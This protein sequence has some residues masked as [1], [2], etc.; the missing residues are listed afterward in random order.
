MDEKS[1]LARPFIKYF[2]FG[3]LTLLCGLGLYAGW[4]Y[5][6]T[7]TIEDPT[8]CLT[9]QMNQIEL[10]PNRTSY[11]HYKEVPKHFFQALILSEDA[12][13]YS[14]KG[15]DWFEIKESFR[16][17]FV[18]WRFSRGGSTLTQQLAKNMY[19]SPEKSLSRKFK[20]FFI[21]KQLERKLSKSQI[22]EK[23]VNIVEFG[24]NIYGLKT[25]AQHYFDKT[26]A[27][28]N[29][30]ESVYLVSLLPSPRRLGKSHYHQK[31]SKNNLWRMQ[32]ILRRLYHTG[33]LKDDLYVYMKVLLEEADWPFPQYSDSMFSPTVEQELIE[34]FKTI[35]E[36]M[37][38]L[39]EK[40]SNTT[41]EQEEESF[42]TDSETEAP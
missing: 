27:E 31:L 8:K 2:L 26:P 19:L 24:N 12:S 30:L 10:C 6:Q 42:E 38:K 14:H 9:T 13:F 5:W 40:L 3:N 17:N 29:I 11:L 32:V 4:V 37:V 20:E 1:R 25:A 22:L 28:L 7:Q 21:A 16:R 18:E 34:E 35:E 15:F 23:Y 36:N 41:G 33:R 39:Q